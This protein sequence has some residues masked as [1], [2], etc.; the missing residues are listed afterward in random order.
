MIQRGK[1]PRYPAGGRNDLN[2][3]QSGQYA[4]E[5]SE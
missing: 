4:L 1:Q 2:A 3:R 5:A